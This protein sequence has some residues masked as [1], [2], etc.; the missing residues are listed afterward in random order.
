[1]V[2]T[3]LVPLSS[4]PSP[5]QTRS[6]KIYLSTLQNAFV[7]IANC[8]SDQLKNNIERLASLS[9]AP[10][11]TILQPAVENVFFQIKKM[12]LPELTNVFV[13]IAKCI[14][15][16]LTNGFYL[17]GLSFICSIGI[18][19][20]VSIIPKVSFKISLWRGIS[21]EGFLQSTLPFWTSGSAGS[22]YQW[23]LF[24]Y[25]NQSKHKWNGEIV[26][27]DEPNQKNLF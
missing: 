10:P 12:Y 9:S 14:R 7:K 24:T 4:A 17:A 21:L 1:M 19:Q 25:I 15:N 13:R 3:W 2:S 20:P 16:Q 5:S 27:I 26:P 8:I 6:C 22:W 11:L 23:K 18:P